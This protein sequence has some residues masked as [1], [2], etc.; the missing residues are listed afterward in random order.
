M[1]TAATPGSSSAAAASIGPTAAAAN[2]LR[3]NAAC[4]IPGRVKSPVNRPRPV[5]IRRSS[6]RGSAAPTQR[7]DG[8]SAASGAARFPFSVVVCA[9]APP[10]MPRSPRWPTR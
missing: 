5:S 7:P 6:L 4:S 9:P 1:N 3:A 2:G 8:E 10:V